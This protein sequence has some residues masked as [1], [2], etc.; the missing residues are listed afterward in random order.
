MTRNLRRG[1]NICHHLPPRPGYPS[2]RAI[3][4]LSS[5]HS[6]LARFLLTGGFMIRAAHVV[7]FAF[8]AGA[9]HCSSRSVVAVAPDVGEAGSS[10][11]ARASV[12]GRASVDADAAPNPAPADDATAKSDDASLEGTDADSATNV[13]RGDEPNAP[14]ANLALPDACAARTPTNHRAQPSACTSTQGFPADAA[15]L[16]CTT[17]A[18]CVDAGRASALGTPFLTCLGGRC[19]P[20]QCVS[21]NDCPNGG[22]CSCTG[23][24]FG[25]AHSSL[26]NICLPANCRTDA[27]CGS[28]GYCSPSV[29]GGPFYGIQGYYCRTCQ[30]TCTNDSECGGFPCSTCA[31]NAEHW[32]CILSCGAG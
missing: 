28:G 17:T 22:V 10:G 31:Y 15:P 4:W 11:D 12:D 19:T 7:F 5:R 30:D 32:A 25:Y 20:D 24:T 27:D 16:S 26:G 1:G 2:E 9:I 23:S 29:S 8:A 13:V 6:V 21:D 14:D 18:D 3:L